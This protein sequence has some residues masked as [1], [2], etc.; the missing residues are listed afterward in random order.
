LSCN[1]NIHSLFVNVGKALIDGAE[2]ILGCEEVLGAEEIDG[3]L[4]VVGLDESVGAVLE[5]AVETYHQKKI[6]D[7]C[8]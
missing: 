8:T 6:E 5:E 4:L 2:L 3:L 7:E 1:H